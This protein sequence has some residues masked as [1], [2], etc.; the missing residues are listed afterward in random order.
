M[1]PLYSKLDLRKFVLGFGSEGQIRDNI[2][3]IVIFAALST[4][5]GEFARRR[6]IIESF[7]H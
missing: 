7:V 3:K 2:S 1:A 4:C 6:K 5:F